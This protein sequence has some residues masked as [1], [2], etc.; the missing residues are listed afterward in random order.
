MMECGGVLFPLVTEQYQ[1][2][3]IHPRKK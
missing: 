2:P 1:E 3:P